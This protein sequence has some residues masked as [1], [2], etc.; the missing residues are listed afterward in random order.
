MIR[1]FE[2]GPEPAFLRD[3]VAHLGVTSLG[4]VYYGQINETRY[5]Y[6]LGEYR[7]SVDVGTKRNWFSVRIGGAL[8]TVVTTRDG[9]LRVLVGLG[10]VEAQAAMREDKIN[11]LLA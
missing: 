9:L 7:L 4:F 2:D 8:E 5:R 10:C 1:Q 6:E 3:I 11:K